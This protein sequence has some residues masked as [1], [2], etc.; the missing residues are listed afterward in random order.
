METETKQRIMDK[1]EIFL[2]NNLK[3]FV[4]D[5]YNNYYFCFVKEISDDWVILKNFKGNREGENT[6]VFWIDIEVFSEYQ[7]GRK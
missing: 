1:A 6:R 5:I 7:E 4:K 3:A 2:R